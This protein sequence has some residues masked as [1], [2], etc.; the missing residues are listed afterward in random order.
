MGGGAW[1]EN[2]GTFGRGAHHDIHTFL[3]VSGDR[4]EGI[5]TG[6]KVRTTTW[7]FSPGIRYGYTGPKGSLMEIGFALPVGLNRDAPDWGWIVQ[8]QLEFP[9]S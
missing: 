6:S 1:L 2:S 8:F 3:E 9:G 7:L 4:A 5:E